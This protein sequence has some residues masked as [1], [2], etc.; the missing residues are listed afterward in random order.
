MEEIKSGCPRDCYSS[1]SVILSLENGRIAGIKGDPLNKAT[2]GMICIKGRA[3]IERNYGEGRLKYP[4]KRIGKRGEGKFERIS[5]EEAAREISGKLLKYQEERP[6][7]VLYYCGSGASGISKKASLGFWNQLKGYSTVYGT[8]CLA[9]GNE[10]VIQTYGS[11]THNAPWDLENAGCIVLWGKNP[12]NTNIQEMGFINRAI[13]RGGKLIVIDPIKTKSSVKSDMHIM[14]KNGTDGALALALANYMIENGMYDKE[15][16]DNYAYGF[17]EYRENIKKYTL[18]FAEMECGVQ[19]NEVVKLAEMLWNSRPLTL[20]CGYGI[21]RYTN[22]GQTVRAI[23]LIPALV[24]DIG[25]RGGGFRYL[26]RSPVKT[27]WPYNHQK[28]EIFQELHIGRFGHEILDKGIKMMWVEMANPAVSNPNTSKV[29]EALNS[30]DYLVVVEQYMSDTAAYGDIILPAAATFEYYDLINSYWHPYLIFVDR[31]HEPLYECKHESEIYR[32]LGKRMGMDLSFIP[33]NNIALIEKI[34]AE[35]KINVTVE[36]LRKGPYLPEDYNEI[37]FADKKFNTVT[38][39]IQFKAKTLKKWHTPLLPEYMS[40]VEIAESKYPLLFMS[41]HSHEKINSQYSNL[42]MIRKAMGP[43]MVMINEKD[44]R[45]RNIKEGD[46]ISIF[47]DRGSIKAQA[48][49]TEDIKEGIVNLYEGFS[50]FDGANANILTEDRVTDMG[51][52]TAFHNCCVDIRVV[53]E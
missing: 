28:P 20:I 47:N 41:S 34:L 43:I 13:Q 52:G 6:E 42:E 35:S 31:A 50:N 36:E 21:Q 14:P 38:G 7:A 9:T 40:P 37:A 39:K 18:E 25:V 51:N 10:A 2:C 44:A 3:Y 24:G 46:V 15:F 22:G 17:E 5:W 26:N 32:L 49:V 33:E 4:L 53:C 19:K 27:K 11:S 23:S 29:I 16:I 30:L 1:C 48:L 12:A 45:E 8:L